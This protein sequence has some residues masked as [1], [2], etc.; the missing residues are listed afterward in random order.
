MSR[1]TNVI[2]TTNVGPSH[3]G[4]PEIDTVNTSLRNAIT[5]PNG[6]FVE[7]SRHA[8]GAKHMEVRVYLAA[9][10]HVDAEVILQAVHHVPWADIEMVQVFIKEQEDEVFELRYQAGKFLPKRHAAT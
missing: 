10:N 9:F 6:E 2:L 4:D 5:G 8:G 3:G 1:V 7:V